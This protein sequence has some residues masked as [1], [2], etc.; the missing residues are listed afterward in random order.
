MR[1]FLK[2]LQLYYRLTFD[3]DSF[4]LHYGYLNTIPT[5]KPTDKNNGPIPWMSYDMVEFLDEKLN[6][7][8]SLFEY[9]VGYSTMYFSKRVKS[10]KSIEH[11]SQW[12]NDIS[13]SLEH[14]E[15]V[16]IELVELENGYE[17]AIKK[18][19]GKFDIILIDGRKRAT[20]AINS[21]DKLSDSGVLILDD[22]NRDYYQPAF[23]FYLKKGFRKI[24]FSGLAPTSFRRHITTIFYRAGNNCF[25][26]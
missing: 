22:S 16:K 1:K 12:F 26:I 11:H 21:F 7:N 15:N 3:P 4:F 18:E 2:T 23:D 10:V 6:K 25:D 17:E 20:C 13:S 19:Q 8:L 5:G 9:G 14:M 24:S